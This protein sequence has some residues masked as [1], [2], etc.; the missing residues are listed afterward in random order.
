MGG[1]LFGV[2]LVLGFL[3]FGCRGMG[4][5]FRRS[6]LFTIYFL[7]IRKV[8]VEVCNVSHGDA[9]RIITH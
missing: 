8:V 7:I 6:S 1:S 9:V 4:I 3:L 2:F 5:F